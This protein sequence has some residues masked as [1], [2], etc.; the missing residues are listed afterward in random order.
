MDGERE[1]VLGG[2]AAGELG[3]GR[4]DLEAVDLEAGD[5]GGEAERG[6][7]G[8]AAELEH[9]LAGAGGDEGGEQHRVGG[10]AVAGPRLP[11]AQPAVEEARRG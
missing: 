8:A 9:A 7:A 11:E 4:L 2:V 1:M 10:G 6:G 3:V 5:A